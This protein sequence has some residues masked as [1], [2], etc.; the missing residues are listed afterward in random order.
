MLSMACPRRTNSPSRSYSPVSSI[1]LRSTRT[2]STTSSLRAIRSSRSKPSERTF[3]ASS[4]NG[5]LEAHQHAG[6]AILGGAADEE[7][8]RHQRLAAA[9][10]A[11]DQR[12]PPARKA[13]ERDFVQPPNA[14]RRLGELRLNVGNVSTCLGHPECPFCVHRWS[15]SG[16]SNKQATRGRASRGEGIGEPPGTSTAATTCRSGRCRPT[17]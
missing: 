10:A 7:L 2:K 9:G 15:G 11:A 14:G 5:L 1:S 16:D 6:F 17:P 13:A 4:L 12:R 3:C 8:H